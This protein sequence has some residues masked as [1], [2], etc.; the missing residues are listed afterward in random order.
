MHNN[1]TTLSLLALLVA[2]AAV[3]AAQAGREVNETRELAPDGTVSIEL[4]SGSVR[5]V[6]GSG[7]TVEISGTIGD[8]VERLEIDAS[9]NSVEIEV[10]LVEGRHRIYDAGADLVIR[11]PRGAEIQA[12]TVSASISIEDVEGEV[13]IESVSGDV[14]IDSPVREAEVETVSSRVEVTDRARL[15]SGSFETVSGRIN[16]EA[17]IADGRFSFSAVSG[18]IVLRL[19]SDTSAE[20]EV[21]TFSGDIDNELGPAATKTSPYLPSKSLEFSLGRGGARV[22]VESFSGSVKLLRR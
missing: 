13:S 21:E 22:S 4:I 10:H 17:S 3:T 9:A 8:D 19:G 20:F 2:L 14:R 6:G 18:D 7:S 11:V 15:R 1:K 16:F 12:E 5:F